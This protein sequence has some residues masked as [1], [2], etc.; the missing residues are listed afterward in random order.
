M[1]GMPETSKCS[2]GEQ[3]DAGNYFFIMRTRKNAFAPA[4][5]ETVRT[6]TGAGERGDLKAKVRETRER[7]EFFYDAEPPPWPDRE[8]GRGFAW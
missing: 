3:R 8:A 5:R 1:G 6:R 4:A 7:Y 2:I